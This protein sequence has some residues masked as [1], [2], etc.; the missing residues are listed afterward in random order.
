MPILRFATAP[1]FT[2]GGG[3][4]RIV[5]QWLVQKS[6]RQ[7]PAEGLCCSDNSDLEV[8]LGANQQA[9][10]V[11]VLQLIGRRRLGN[12]RE[13]RRRDHLPEYFWSRS[14]LR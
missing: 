5:D 11:L 6:P 3:S 8:A 7:L 10:G 2:A 13:R 1:R 14:L 4:V 9:V 12:A